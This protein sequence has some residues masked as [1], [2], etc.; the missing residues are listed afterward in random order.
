MSLQNHENF[1]RKLGHI[2]QGWASQS[3]FLI[4]Y[5]LF[6]TFYLLDTFY[7]QFSFI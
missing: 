4:V 2:M 1:P 3:I 6:K 5:K 7:F